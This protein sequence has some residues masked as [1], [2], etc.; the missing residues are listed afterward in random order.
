MLQLHSGD[1]SLNLYNHTSLVL[2][3]DVQIINVLTPTTKLRTQRHLNEPGKP[4]QVYKSFF[5]ED[6]IRLEDFM[7]RQIHYLLQNML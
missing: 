1:I 5:P 7:Q 6:A 3:R 2:Y 4:S